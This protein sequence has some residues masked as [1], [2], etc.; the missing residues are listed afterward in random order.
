MSAVNLSKAFLL[1]ER[2]EQFL[3]AEQYAAMKEEYDLLGISVSVHH[4]AL[5]PSCT[6]LSLEAHGSRVDKAKSHVMNFAVQNCVPPE[7][8]TNTMFMTM[9]LFGDCFKKVSCQRP[10]YN[11]RF[12]VLIDVGS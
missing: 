7:K 6:L 10:V 4:A 12:I 1:Y 3:N 2:G 8:T 11:V 5:E 9:A